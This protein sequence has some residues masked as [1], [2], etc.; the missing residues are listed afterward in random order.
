MP[1]QSVRQAPAVVSELAAPSSQT[2]PP[3]TIPSPQLVVQALP[4]ISQYHPSSIAEQSAVQPSPELVLPS[5]QASPLSTTPSPQ[6][7]PE[8]ATPRPAMANS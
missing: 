1:E 4:A 7:P 3:A 5:S 2:S 8:E 6:I